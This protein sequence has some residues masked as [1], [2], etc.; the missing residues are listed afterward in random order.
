MDALKEQPVVTRVSLS[1]VQFDFLLGLPRWTEQ[2]GAAC[3]SVIFFSYG[4]FNV[5]L[6]RV[7][8]RVIQPVRFLAGT[9]VLD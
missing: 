9:S 1:F 8:L 6:S 7:A 4:D 5:G 2:G 3:Y